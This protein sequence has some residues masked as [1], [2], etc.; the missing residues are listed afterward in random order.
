[1]TEPIDV[2]IANAHRVAD[3]IAKI[4]TCLQLID[5]SDCNSVHFPISVPADQTIPLYQPKSIKIPSL[6]DTN[7]CLPE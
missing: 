3:N 7:Y 2:H 6:T 1:M 5:I 4:C